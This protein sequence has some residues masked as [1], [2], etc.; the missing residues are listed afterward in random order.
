MYLVRVV[1][2][3]GFINAEVL[4]LLCASSVLLTFQESA[5]FRAV[6]TWCNSSLYYFTLIGPIKGLYPFS[7]RPVLELAVNQVTTSFLCLCDPSMPFSFSIISFLFPSFFTQWWHRISK[8]LIFLHHFSRWIMFQCQ[9]ALQATSTCE[10]FCSSFDILIFTD[11]GFC[12]FCFCSRT[13]LPIVMLISM[14]FLH[15]ANLSYHL[16]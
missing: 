8:S 11:C 15:L 16:A 10:V 7:F 13:F 2:F 3:W 14:S 12:I 6:I 9:I 1:R 4:I 5:V